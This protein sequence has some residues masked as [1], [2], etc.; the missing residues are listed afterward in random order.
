[1]KKLLLSFFALTLSLGGIGCTPKKTKTQGQTKTEGVA[2]EIQMQTQTILSDFVT[3]EAIV[4]QTMVELNEGW[5]SVSGKQVIYTR[6]EAGEVWISV[7]RVDESFLKKYETYHSFTREEPFA[8]KIAFIPNVPVKDFS[9][10]A[11]LFRDWDS[12][13]VVFYEI[14]ELYK[15]D[16][17]HPQ[18]PLVVSWV[19]VGS[20]SRFGFS[21]RDKDGQ[22]NYFTG[23]ENYA[24]DMNTEEYGPEYLIFRL[25]P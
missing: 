20:M 22:I 23:V 18:K 19:D 2:T 8:Q 12:N 25:I 24:Y 14:Y 1:M 5:F 3:V 17:L 11:V 15:M 4:E 16:E 7:L 21:Y 9:W 10:L 13:D 6:D